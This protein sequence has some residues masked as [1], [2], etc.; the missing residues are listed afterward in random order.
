MKTEEKE[1][2]N[3]SALY[4]HPSISSIKTIPLFLFK[5]S[6][7]LFSLSVSL[8]HSFWKNQTKNKTQ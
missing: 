2:K 1:G 7:L 8:S 4:Y 6:L 5:K 3:K